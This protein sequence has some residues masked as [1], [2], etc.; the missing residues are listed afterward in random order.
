MLPTLRS[1]V[2]LG[3][4]PDRLKRTDLARSQNPRH[5]LQMATGHLWSIFSIQFQCS[6]S[7]KS[8]I[9][10]KFKPTIPPFRPIETNCVL[11]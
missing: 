2:R 6:H 9:Y 11:N 5:S 3:I 10:S 1:P 7:P 4:L 8:A